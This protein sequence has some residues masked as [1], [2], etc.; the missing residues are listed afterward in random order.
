ML[1]P[2]PNFVARRAYSVRRYSGDQ[3]GWNPIFLLGGAPVVWSDLLIDGRGYHSFTLY[4]AFAPV[5]NSVHFVIW[6][7]D[8]GGTQTRVDAARDQVDF[9]SVNGAA[10]IGRGLDWGQY[11]G[12]GGGWKGEILGWFQLG[13][14]T[15]NAALQNGN[16]FVRGIE[17]ASYF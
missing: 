4:Y 16:V 3:L 14:Y 1:Q 2:F 15:D 10:G 8:P 7:L 17:L 9:A 11:T 5:L 13:I 6:Y 12:G